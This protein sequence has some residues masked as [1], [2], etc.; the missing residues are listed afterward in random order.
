MSINSKFIL[1]EAE[2][3]ER[4]LNQKGIDCKILAVA[5]QGQSKRLI[6]EEIN[7]KVK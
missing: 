7:R 2:E 5:W 3:F 4:K 1:K 6:V